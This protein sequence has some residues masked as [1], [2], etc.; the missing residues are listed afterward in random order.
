M[1][2]PTTISRTRE[3]LLASALLAHVGPV[4]RVPAAGLPAAGLTAILSS[5]AATLLGL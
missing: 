1:G 2:C 3:D 4:D 5:N